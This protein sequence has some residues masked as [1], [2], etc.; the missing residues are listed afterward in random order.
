MES[1]TQQLVNLYNNLGQKVGPD[2]EP[3]LTVSQVVTTTTTTNTYFNQRTFDPTS[4]VELSPILYPVD[5]GAIQTSLD[6]ISA[7]QDTISA[8][9]DLI[10]QASATPGK[11]IKIKKGGTVASPAQQ[12]NP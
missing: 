6:E 8:I 2:G 4:G 11:L 9:Q 5:S 3:I 7:E 10:S 12:V 1:N